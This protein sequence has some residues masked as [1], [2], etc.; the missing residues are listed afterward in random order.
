M[1]KKQKILLESEINLAEFSAL[2]DSFYE[3]YERY[4][5]NFMNLLSKVSQRL[6][7]KSVKA[8]LE[9]DLVKNLYSSNRDWSY[10]CRVISGNDEDAYSLAI[11]MMDN[12][13]YAIDGSP[14]YK[15]FRK[16]FFEANSKL[17]ND[18]VVGTIIN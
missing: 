2:V 16:L 6:S 7:N 8:A 4:N 9:H 14:N 10:F 11:R 3:V 1:K 5:Y 15:M 12:I 13:D 18:M 17:T